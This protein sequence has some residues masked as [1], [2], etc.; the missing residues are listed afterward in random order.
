[1]HIS[2]PKLPGGTFGLLNDTGAQ[3]SAI[4]LGLV[5]KHRLYIRSILSGEPTHLKLAA[6][7]KIVHRIG[8]V[9]IPITIHFTGVIHR[10]PYHCMKSFE[11][12]D[13]DYDFILGVD[14][15]PTIF[16]HDEIMKYILKPS[17]I[18]SP[19]QEVSTTADTMVLEKSVSNS[20]VNSENTL[21]FMYTDDG[22]QYNCE[23]QALVM[24]DYV[25][26]RVDNLFEQLWEWDISQYANSV[27]E[28]LRK[29]KDARDKNLSLSIEFDP[30]TGCRTFC[31]DFN[32]V[33]LKG[34][35]FKPRSQQFCSMIIILRVQKIHNC[36]LNYHFRIRSVTWELVVFLLV[37]YPRSQLCQHLLKKKV[38]IKK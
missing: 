6:K 35:W 16:P 38:N 24:N 25:S 26:E 34:I 21:E 30:Q 32:K 23:P 17:I 11:V 28:E 7:S 27:T 36:I 37:K 1:M 15:L 12:L 20:D 14:I 22:I 2:S 13:M 10:S 29:I 9:M 8:S 5:K 33:I 18:S 19:P 4:S 3:F 31:N